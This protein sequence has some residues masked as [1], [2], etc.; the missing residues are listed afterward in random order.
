M[1]RHPR[2]LAFIALAALLVLAFLMRSRPISTK[3]SPAAAAAR[4]AAAPPAAAGNALPQTSGLLAQIARVVPQ[5]ADASPTPVQLGTQPNGAIRFLGVQRGWQLPAGLARVAANPAETARNFLLAN[6]SSFGLANPR[7]DL[8]IFRT[9]PNP[10]FTTVR[11]QQT[12]GSLPVLAAETVVHVGNSDE[13]RTILADLATQVPNLDRLPLPLVPTISGESA[14]ERAIAAVRTELKRGPLKASAPQLVVYAPDVLGLDGDPTLAWEVPVESP[15]DP[16]T[17]RGR[18][19]IDADTGALLNFLDEIHS[20]TN[21]R[22][23]DDN[24]ST[25]TDPTLGGAGDNAVRLEGAPAT[26]ITEVDNLYNFIGQTDAF[27]LSNH[28]RNGYNGAGG[29][30]FAVARSVPAGQTAPWANANAGGNVLQFGLGYVADDIVA[31]EYTHLVTEQTSRL[32]YQNASGA[33]NEALS[34]VFGEFMDLTNTGQPSNGNDAANVRWLVGEDRPAGP[35]RSMSDPGDL[36][37]PLASRRFNDPD[38]LSSTN[39]K[40]VAVVPNGAP[41]GNDNGGVHSNSGVCNKLCF[42]ITDGSTF[43]GQTITPEGIGNVATLFYQVQVNYLV[44]ASDWRDLYFAITNAAANLAWSAPRQINVNHACTAVE[45]NTS[46]HDYYI[47]R[48]SPTVTGSPPQ[49]I[50]EVG[51]PNVSGTFGPFRSIAAGISAVNDGGTLNINGAAGTY[52]A[53]SG[54]PITLVKPMTLKSYNS[55]TTI[56]P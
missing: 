50:Q 43:N 44:P 4:P 14:P 48:S 52:N 41:G 24:S 55:A 53:N 22:I 33:I 30:I 7:F 1:K 29:T 13:I 28:Q 6:R 47:D 2:F 40:P 26:G 18:A 21:R 3:H 17:D 27:Y 16:V 54:N 20:A 35:I 49:S 5:V 42:L 11:L 23:Y 10:T 39:Y 8:T 19:I 45:I 9:F 51:I 32:L 56:V 31:H 38:R 15:G 12:Y 25:T 36:L 34:D 46:P 37:L